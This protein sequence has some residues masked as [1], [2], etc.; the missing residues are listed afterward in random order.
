LEEFQKNSLDQVFSFA[1][2]VDNPLGHAPDQS[3]IAVNKN[4]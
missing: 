3:L 2:V 4:S 1:L